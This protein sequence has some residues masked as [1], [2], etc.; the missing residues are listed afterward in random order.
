MI[1]IYLGE[2]APKVQNDFYNNCDQDK[3]AHAYM[4]LSNFKN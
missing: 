1:N 2:I 4:A 3:S